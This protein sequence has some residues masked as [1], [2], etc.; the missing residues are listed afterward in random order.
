MLKFFKRMERTRNFLIILFAVILV[1]SLIV[2]GALSGNQVNADLSRS[3]DAVATVGSETITIGDVVTQQQ[4]MQQLQRGQTLPAN[5]MIDG[6]IREKLVKIEAERLGLTASDAE[7]ANRIREA[8]QSPDGTPIDQER[9]IQNAIR[10]AG[11]VA[12]FEEGIRDRLSLEKVQ[13][14]VTSGVTVSEEEVLKD[15]KRKNTKFTL[16]YVPIST[17]DLAQNITPS[18][19]ELKAYF[20]E[21]KK[22]YYI[23][24]PQKKIRYIYLETAKVGEKL[25]I[26]DEDLKAQYDKL[27][28]ERKQAGVNVQEIVLRVPKEEFDGDVLKK[29]NDIVKR[30]KKDTESSSEENFAKIAQG[31]SEN[32]VTANNGGRVRG[33]VQRATDPTKQDDPYQRILTLKEGDITEPIKFGTNYYILRRGKAVEKSFEDMKKGLDASARNTKAYAANA[34]LAGKVAEELKKAVDVKQV[35]EK[36]ASEAN[37]SVDNMIRETGYIKPGDEVEKLGASQD[38]E[39]G[40]A[41]LEKANDVGDKIPVPGGFAIPLVVDVKEP[42]DAEFDE[43]KQKVL[44]AVKVKQATDK[45]EEVANSIAASAASGGLSSAAT[46]NKLEAKEA[47]DFIL[48]SP[49]GE[50]PSATTSEALEDAI[51]ALK[52]GE[53]TKEPIKVGDN[54]YVVS[55]KE[56]E[57]ASTEDFNKQRDQLVQQM[58]IGKKG[59]VFSDYLAAVRQRMEKAGEIEIYKDALAKIDA[60]AQQNA[61]PPAPP[62]Q[63][64]LPNGQQIPPELLQQIQQQQQQQPPPQGQ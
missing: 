24:L 25:D 49:L 12:A 63:Q 23:S 13:A 11:S 40:I 43:V 10:Q 47:K 38:F 3:N 51:Y 29:A 9:Y 4:Q 5:M 56:R 30:L 31:E 21:N 54:Y 20:E 14:F 15:Y 22:D 45:L 41:G 60:F 34:T 35:A 57:E 1:A 36:F 32:P 33:L 44:E 48:G 61:P 37:M 17:A 55:V 62:Q 28:E 46:A 6:M 27:P 58:L 64:Q 18:D 16:S 42:R 2:F 8:N 53:V 39:Q 50:G 59:Q 19:E 26:S 52:E 7:L